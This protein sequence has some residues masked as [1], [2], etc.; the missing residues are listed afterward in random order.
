MASASVSAAT[1]DLVA[2][3]ARLEE[4]MN[5]VF[6]AVEKLA[7]RDAEFDAS[8]RSIS[9]HFS[10]ALAAQAEEFRKSLVALTA[11]PAVDEARNS[12]LVPTIRRLRDLFALGWSV[13]LRQPR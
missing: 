13:L 5:D 2:R 7:I 12:S 6:V 8:L 3:L 1:N 11:N 4:R 10:L 9:E